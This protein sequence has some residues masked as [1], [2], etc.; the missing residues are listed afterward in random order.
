MLEFHFGRSPEDL[1]QD[2]DLASVIIQCVNVSFETLEGTFL[3][4]HGFAHRDAKPDD[5][6]AVFG[7]RS[8]RQLLLT[9]NN[10]LDS[11]PTVE[12][13]AKLIFEYGASQGLPI[14]RVKVWETPTS[15]AEY[16]ERR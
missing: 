2:L 13:I 10:F 16:G 11:N 15:S 8:C 1:D 14:V 7:L 3:D 6:R 9:F 5:R 4:L 12:L